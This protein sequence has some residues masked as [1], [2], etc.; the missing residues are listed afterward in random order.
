MDIYRQEI[1]DH[2]KNPRNSGEMKDYTTK[3]EEHNPLCGDKI[4][5]FL[6]IKKGVVEDMKFV[7]EGC[8]ISKASASMISDSIKGLTKD[9]ICK[10]ELEDVRRILGIPLSPSRVKCAMLSLNSIKRSFEC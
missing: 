3:H 7:A 6:K 4:T 8:A 1:M 9:N 5:V 2:F 10:M